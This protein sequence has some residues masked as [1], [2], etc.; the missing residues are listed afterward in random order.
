ML[1]NGLINTYYG[2]I[3]SLKREQN[4]VST[5]SKITASDLD[6]IFCPL[7]ISLFK[8]PIYHAWLTRI[9]S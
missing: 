9:G 5:E 4:L 2:F 7:G 3:G 1:S 6:N 8:N